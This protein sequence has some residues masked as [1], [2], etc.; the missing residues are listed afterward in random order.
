MGAIQLLSKMVEGNKKVY[1]HCSAGMYRSP[2]I[3]ALFLILNQNYSVEEAIKLVKSRH[4]FA[5]PN[6]ETVHCALNLY[7]KK[8]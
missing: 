2:Q 5:R 1:V 7:N 3:V 6:P 4:R 8:K